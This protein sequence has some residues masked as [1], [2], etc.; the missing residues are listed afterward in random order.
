M[1]NHTDLEPA[2]IGSVRCDDTDALSGDGD[3][4]EAEWGRRTFSS[5]EERSN[6]S[7]NL[8]FYT[9]GGLKAYPASIRD[10]FFRNKRRERVT[11]A[12]TNNGL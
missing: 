11:T 8:S 9:T 3:E 6:P 1:C 10:E 4:G 5:N 7:A 2:I 12:Q